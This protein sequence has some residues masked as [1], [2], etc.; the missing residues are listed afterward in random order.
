V[1]SLKR[2]LPSVEKKEISTF[3]LLAFSKCKYEI[4]STGLGITV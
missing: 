2:K 3:S 4:L 1:T